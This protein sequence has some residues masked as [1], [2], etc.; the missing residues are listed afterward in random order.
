MRHKNRK[1][2]RLPLRMQAEDYWDPY[3]DAQFFAMKY[4]SAK[5]EEQREKVVNT[6]FAFGANY[7]IL[8][9]S[10][11]LFRYFEEQIGQGIDR[12]WIGGQS[13]YGRTI[14]EILADNTR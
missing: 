2:L 9:R 12:L 3:S 7:D 1:L 10:S 13:S 5:T 11:I 8:T 6:I 4:K 14:D